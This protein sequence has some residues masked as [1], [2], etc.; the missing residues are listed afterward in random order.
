MLEDVQIKL[1]L[2]SLKP[3]HAE[4]LVD[5]YNHMTSDKGIPIIKS[6]WRAAVITDAINLGLENLPSIDP[7]EE[8][9]PMV[10]SSASII[11]R[12]NQQ[13]TAVANLNA[14]ELSILNPS[15][16][17]EVAS[18]DDDSDW[19]D[20]EQEERSAFDLFDEEPFDE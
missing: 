13:L 12:D 18:S 11:D 20:P 1:R 4:W 6:G 5:F 19:E 15:N 10:D 9:D 14:D 17:K 7:F 16:S 2:S 3:L 8:I